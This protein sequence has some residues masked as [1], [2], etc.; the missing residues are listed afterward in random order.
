MEI[1]NYDSTGEAADKNS[2]SYILLC[3]QIL[4]EC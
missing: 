2:N 4:F 3:H 1:P